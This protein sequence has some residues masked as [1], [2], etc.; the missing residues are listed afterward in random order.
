MDTRRESALQLFHQVFTYIDTEEPSL[1][2]GIDWYTELYQLVVSLRD[3]LEV[4][5]IWKAYLAKTTNERS[6]WNKQQQAHHFHVFD[7]VTRHVQAARCDSH[8]DTAE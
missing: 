1:Q 6:E 7:Y 8:S 4:C 5:E 2:A 3:P